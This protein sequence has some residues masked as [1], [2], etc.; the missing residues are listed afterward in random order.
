MGKWIEIIKSYPEIE[1][2]YLVNIKDK[3]VFCRYYDKRLADNYGRSK[4]PSIGFEDDD[5]THWMNIPNPP[6]GE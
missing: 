2:Q 5:I 3:G 4:I 6:K 1:G